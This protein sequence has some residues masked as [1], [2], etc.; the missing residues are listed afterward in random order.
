MLEGEQDLTLKQLNEATQA[1]MEMEYHRKR[2]SVTLQTPLE[3]LDQGPDVGRPSP[4]PQDLRLA[5]TIESSRALRRSDI[6]ISI[7]AVRYEI[8]SAYWHLKRIHVRYASW[9]LSQV[10]IIDQHSGKILCRI[11]PRD[12]EKNADRRR[13][14]I[15]VQNPPKPQ[16][17]AGVAP[18]LATLIDDYKSTGLPMGY[19]ARDE[20]KKK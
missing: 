10:H 15:E 9:D 4:S 20:R 8:P 11:L 7:D 3:R 12:L 18:L 14:A 1:W 13:R 19:L 16:P 6:S 5:F 17:T 2:H